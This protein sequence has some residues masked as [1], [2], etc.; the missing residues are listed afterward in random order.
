LVI[1]LG[2]H[3]F[4]FKA[5]YGLPSSGLFWHQCFDD[6]LH[7]MGVVQS[8]AES[9]IWMRENDRRYEY[10]AAHVNDLLFAARDPGEITW[11][12]EESHRFKL[13]GVGP[14]TYHF[15]CDYFHD[16]DGTLC[17]GPRK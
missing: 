3:F 14:L 10:I 13:K 17:Y 5:L 1:L 11:T 12:L 2:M 8:R 6:V 9:D 4:I 16:K 15:G 7:F